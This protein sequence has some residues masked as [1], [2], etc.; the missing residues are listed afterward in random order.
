MNRPLALIAL[1]ICLMSCG[2]ER[3][4]IPAEDGG[5]GGRP[6]QTADDC[7]PPMVCY[8]DALACH[9]TSLACQQRARSYCVVICDHD[10]PCRPGQTCE[11][12]TEDVGRCL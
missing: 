1:L 11:P 9:E 7:T 3:R 8:L 12:V 6:C 2:D 4:R 5:T 10:T